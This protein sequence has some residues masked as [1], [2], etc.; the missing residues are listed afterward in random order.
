MR[1]DAMIGTRIRERRVMNGLR[2]SEL[3]RQV[4]ISPSYLN[5][6]EHNRRRIGGKTLLQIAEVLGVEAT[7]LSEGAEATL[8][9]ALSE[10]AAA[11]PEAAP[12]LS[13]A[14]EFAGRFPGWAGLLS[15][16]NRRRDALERTVEVLTERLAHDP[17]LAAS[18]HEV[19]STVT[20][21]RSTA[22]IL[23]ET[24]EL[25]PEWQMRF[26]RNIN[27]DSHR[28]AEGAEALM[29]YL[30][31]APDTG[32]EIKSPQD[33]LHA[34]LEAHGFHFPALEG[35]GGDAGVGPL[36]DRGKALET[37]PARAL[38]RDVLNEYRRDAR[39]LPMDVLEA[40]LAQH[41]LAPDRIAR[42]ADVP[43]AVAF[44]R[45]AMMPEAV[46]GPVGLVVAD[47]AGA[48][49]LR[50]PVLGFTIPQIGAACTLWPL[51][52]ALTQPGVPIAVTLHQGDT[53]VRA[54]AVTEHVAP[55]GFDAPVLV[56]SHMLI[57]PEETGEAQAAAR[58]VGVTCRICPLGDCN[59]RR[60]PS[61]LSAGV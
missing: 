40:A 52:Q 32:A 34:F 54:L 26:H 59:A 30:E 60:E 31:A 25:E 4:G 47:G 7:V 57:L 29:R 43:L 39:A 3:A 12:E 33:E 37:T 24:R 8:I 38:A 20:S 27:E 44:R 17:Q 41:G 53:R 58:T 10:A 1:T 13:R 21:I 46:T 19:I 11:H 22:T 50:K 15:E 35:V 49:L 9:A 5:L 45:L 42:Q 36:L 14:E 28:L 51:Y 6:I 56:R 48:L 2:Q 55:P 23:A 18:L 61:I 16:I